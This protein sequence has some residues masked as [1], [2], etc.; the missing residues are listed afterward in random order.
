MPFKN[1]ELLRLGQ[2]IRT[3]RRLIGLTQ[4]EFAAKCG[5]DRGYFG[6]VER[7]N[8][9]ITFGILC[10]ICDGLDC[11]IAAITIDIPRAYPKGEFLN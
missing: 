5:L 3:G 8:R 7:G 1:V 2:R 4:V 11:D 10:T 6:D 9:N